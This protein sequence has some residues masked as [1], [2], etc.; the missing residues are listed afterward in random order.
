VEWGPVD[1]FTGMA[2]V[3][4]VTQACVKAWSQRSTR[5]RD[6]A[7]NNLVVVD[8]QPAAQQLAAA[9]KATRPAKPKSTSWAQLK[10]EWRADA[11]GLHLDRAAHLAARTAR[12]AAARVRLRTR[13]AGIVAQIDKP[14]LRA[15]IS[16]SWSGRCSRWT[17]PG[18][19]AI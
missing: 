9:Q 7:H 1:P 11:R 2:E 19:R 18:I 13:L 10:H 8:G 15:P 14:A 17:H 6:W 3:A 16:W 4:G 12:R 5:L